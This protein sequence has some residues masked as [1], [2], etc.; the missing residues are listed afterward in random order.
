MNHLFRITD[1]L[2]KSVPCNQ[3]TDL[4]KSVM[5][6]CKFSDAQC[7]KN[8]A[9]DPDK[10]SLV[11]SGAT[12]HSVFDDS[13][14]ISV[15]KDFK[16]HEHT[17][18]LADGS[19]M[20]GMALKK[21][22]IEI[23]LKDSNGKIV[24]GTLDDVLHVPSFPQN[25]FS[26]KAALEKKC[27][28]LFQCDGPSFVKSPDGSV[29]HFMVSDNGLYYLRDHSPPVASLKTK[30][31]V[32]CVTR[33]ME[34]WHQV[35]GHCNQKDLLKLKDVV[36]GMN[37]SGV[38]VKLLVKLVSLARCVRTLIEHLIPDL[39]SQWNLCILI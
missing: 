30:N 11:D 18:E 13:K 27:S 14:F 28:V 17:I 1:V 15:D 23:S 38:L 39:V 9:V 36:V 7:D 31:D 2:P 29:F 25:I 26:V 4:D 5:K 32:V 24:N 35:L 19:K 33:S 22:T 6:P 20:S 10:D 12:R 16:P 3:N 8:D 34:K 21:G 37:I